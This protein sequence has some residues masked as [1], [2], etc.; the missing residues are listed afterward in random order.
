MKSAPI[1]SSAQ[2]N[3]WLKPYYFTRAGFS[4]IWV[5]AALTIGRAMPGIG[6]VLLV[7]YPAWDA[8][9][10]WVDAR[11]AGGLRRNVTQALNVVVSGVATIAV[12]IA[13]GSSLHAV[14]GVFGIW[15]A[16][17]GL[18]QLATGVRRWKS[19]GAQ[20]AMILS[21]A[22]S[23]LAAAHFIQRAAGAETPGIADVAP[24]AAFGAFYFLISAISLAISHARQRRA[25]AGVV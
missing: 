18:F 7:L 5:A 2:D 15:A 22:Q 11:R 20:W 13:L 8:A 6:A 4:I 14:M 3:S 21:G 17:A 12:A 19:H 24:Y 16:L 10:N 25:Q 1:A 23:C 9:A